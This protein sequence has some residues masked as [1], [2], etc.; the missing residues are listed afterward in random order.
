MSKY[1]LFDEGSW[2]SLD[3]QQIYYDK[4]SSTE[5]FFLRS[6][7]WWNEDD[8]G[9]IPI[10]QSVTR[11]TECPFSSRGGR[12]PYILYPDGPMF[13]KPFMGNGNLKK[14]YRTDELAELA[15]KGDVEAGYLLAAYQVYTEK[16]KVEIDAMM[17]RRGWD[18]SD[19]SWAETKWYEQGVAYDE[20]VAQRR[21]ARRG[22]S[23]A[24]ITTRS[25][26]QEIHR[27]TSTPSKVTK[28]PAA[29]YGS[30]ITRSGHSGASI[31]A[32]RFLDTLIDAAITAWVYRSLNLPLPGEIS[33]A[34]LRKYVSRSS[35]QYFAVLTAQHIAPGVCLR[36]RD[37]S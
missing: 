15:A 32:S 27:K 6:A 31:G 21:V 7:N 13:R 33:D 18:E 22:A 4:A 8:V 10:F 36:K 23:R 34:N 17:A 2:Q 24:A 9:L 16:R 1:E 25:E 26:V 29:T 3:F 14:T 30:R 11:P 12:C 5:V 35:T 28:E 20:R 19:R 37:D